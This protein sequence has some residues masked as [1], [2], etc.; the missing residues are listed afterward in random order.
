MTCENDS[1]AR[2]WDL[3]IEEVREQEDRERWELKEQV[4]QELREAFDKAHGLLTTSE[5]V[6]DA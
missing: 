1:R 2:F 4:E 6:S 3:A 5:V